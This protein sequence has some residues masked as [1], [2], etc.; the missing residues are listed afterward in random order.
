MINECPEPGIYYDIPF[1]QYVAWDAVNNSRLKLLERSPLHYKTGFKNEP[2][3]SMALGSL[4]H[5]GVLE[6]LK[7]IER[8]TYMP[9]FSRDVENVTS[10]GERSFSKATKYVKQCEDQFRTAM[11]GKEIIDETAYK[12]MIGISSTLSQCELMQFLRKKG[13]AEVSIVWVDSE[14]GLRCKARADWVRDSQP[15]EP[16]VVL[17]L[18]TTQDAS[19]FE[20]S[21]YKY[22][23]HRQL[24]FY[25]RGF[26]EVTGRA[27]DMWIC[28]VETTEPFGHR[29][30][31]MRES[32][33]QGDREVSALLKQLRDCTDG[34]AWHG[35][36]HP[37]EWLLPEWAK[38]KEV[39]E[40]IIGDETL[41]FGG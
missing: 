1:E 27:A 11:R 2:T 23:Y 9:D 8:Y 13:S 28:A 18:K 6:P 30:A 4:C 17:D 5:A 24:A 41:T 31:P 38:D 39:L 10:G 26:R 37:D 16:L 15:Q 34:N 3:A 19:D 29:V 14:T 22:G 7:L 36:D 20:R 25:R 21:I 33:D 12:K 35:Y 32:L 40:L